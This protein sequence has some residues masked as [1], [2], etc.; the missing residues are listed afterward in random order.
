MK[1][2]KITYAQEKLLRLIE[3]RQL[4]KWCFQHNYD[5]TLMHKI[6]KGERIPT[7]RLMCETCDVISPAEWIYF[8]EEEIPYTVQTVPK[9][10]VNQV[11][12]FLKE[13]KADYMQIAK[14]F[15]L[16][17]NDAYSLFVSYRLRPNL[18]LLRLFVKQINPI[19]FFCDK[20]ELYDKIVYPDSGEVV[21]FN[22]K[23]YFIITSKENNKKTKTA[24]VCTMDENDKVNIHDIKTI[25]LSLIPGTVEIKINKNKIL[26]DVREYLS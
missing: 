15:G 12:Y 22:E 4:K 1:D 13:H 25:S 17:K 11:C 24:V 14:Q 5:H 19:Y 3:E 2:R 21:L 16:E 9:W 18:K 26:K 20:A 23:K 6:A 10:D 8:T 7:Y